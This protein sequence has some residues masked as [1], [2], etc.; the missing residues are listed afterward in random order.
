MPRG[1][2]Q[3]AEPHP[4]A[5]ERGIERI[6]SWHHAV[7]VVTER[8]ETTPPWSPAAPVGPAAIIDPGAEIP[9]PP[10]A[11]PAIAAPNAAFGH[12]QLPP[13]RAAAEERP[14]VRVHIGR[15]EVRANLQPAPPPRRREPEP[16]PELSLTDY[17][18]RSRRP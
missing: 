3:D 15:L 18:R 16:A 8:V 11:P 6:E 14:E 5:A 17:L 9:P 1:A 2:E 10:A 4:P 7:E 12:L 13:M